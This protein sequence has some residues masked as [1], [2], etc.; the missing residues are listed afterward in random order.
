MDTNLL[1]GVALTN[2]HGV[3]QVRLAHGVEVDCHSKGG[4]DLGFDNEKVYNIPG[5]RRLTI[6]LASVG[7]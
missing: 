5:G 4:S 2:G 3:L 7:R 1:L 6:Q